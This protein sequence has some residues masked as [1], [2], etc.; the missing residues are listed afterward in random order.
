MLTWGVVGSFS[1]CFCSH[2]LKTRSHLFAECPYFKKV[3][4]GLMSGF[5][6]RTPGNNWEDELQWDLATFKGKTVLSMTG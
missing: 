4:V 1:C 2:T 3:F 6:N 5:T